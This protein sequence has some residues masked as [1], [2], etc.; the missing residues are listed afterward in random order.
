MYLHELQYEISNVTGT[1][2]D[3]S[4]I[5][6]YFKRNN[7]IHKRLSH[8]ALQRN[9]TLREQYLSDVSIYDPESL[10]FLGEMGS[11]RK[12]ALRM[13]GYSPLGT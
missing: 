9:A 4:T 6:G 2:L 11:D 5:Y 7:F 13:F 8:L 3:E 12:S 1:Q 10:L